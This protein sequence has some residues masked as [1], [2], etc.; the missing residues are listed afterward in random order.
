MRRN[1]APCPVEVRRSN[2]GCAN[3]KLKR[4]T[5]LLAAAVFATTFPAFADIIELKNGQ[6]Y[7][8]TMSRQG[9]SVVIKTEDGQSVTAK[10]A[11]VLRV[12]LTGGSAPSTPDSA[13]AEWSRISSQIKTADSLQA[14]IDLH[15]KFLAKYPNAPEA[16]DVRSS[17]QVYQNL[18]AS[19]GVKFRGRWMPR[20]QIEVTIRQWKDTARPVVDLYHLGKT[21]EALDSAKS[22]LK[23]DDQNPDLLTV[24]GLAAVRNNTLPLAHSYFAALAS[25]DPTNVLAENNLAVVASMQ[26]STS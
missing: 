11:D 20:E 9:D 3:Q 19:G 13:G 8:G 2:M 15:Q 26:K 5:P 23:Q 1:S 25:A 17:L 10:P 18:A 7:T 12:T 22:L 16:D 6:K 24:A 21:K 14:I 4:W